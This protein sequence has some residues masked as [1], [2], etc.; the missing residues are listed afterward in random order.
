MKALAVSIVIP[1]YNHADFLEQAIES[2]LAQ[3][4]PSVE[5]IVLDDG[6]NDKTRD[7]LKAYSGRFYCET[8]QN[9]GQAKTLNKGWAMSKGEYLSYLAA[10]DF[11]LPDA[12]SSAVATLVA[13][14][15]IVMTY[16]D[17]NIVNA[18]SRI[19]RQKRTPDFSYADL[20]V[21]LICQPGPGVFFRRDAFMRAGFWNESLRQTPDFEYWLRLGLEGK[22]ERIPKVLAGYRMHDQSQS[23]G[24][25]AANRADEMV[26]VIS[27]HFQRDR[28]PAEIARAKPE[29]MSNAHIVSARM[30][31]RSGRFLAAL[32]HAMNAF[33]YYPYLYLRPRTWRIFASG[34]FERIGY[35]SIGWFKNKFFAK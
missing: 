34:L 8:H 11:L 21:R 17:F 12:V 19:L 13:N 32:R 31:L 7:I 29:A 27:A 2:V 18:Q 1:A 35:N 4:Y 9:M 28:L 6:S 16:C 14:P 10:D 23:Y 33:R 30:H 3:T 22:F 26:N 15:E 25:I 20:C 24:P 5:L